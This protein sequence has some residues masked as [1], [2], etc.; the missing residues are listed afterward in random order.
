MHENFN[1]A[2]VDYEEGETKEILSK[3]GY[4]EKSLPLI[5]GI[6]FVTGEHLIYNG[7]LDLESITKWMMQNEK[8][9]DRI[10][11]DDAEETVRKAEK[12]AVK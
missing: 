8:Q 1:F 7:V 9:K 12:E 5:Y 11:R 6:D 3:Q 2:I 10:E 4:G